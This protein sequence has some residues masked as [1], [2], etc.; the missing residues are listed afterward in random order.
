[1]DGVKTNT[2]SKQKM[3]EATVVKRVLA[4]EKELF[5]ILVRR[6][7]Q[8]LYRVIRSYL[9]D[10]AEIEDVMQDSFIKAYTKLYQFKLESSFS[11]WLIRIG[12][13]ESLARL[14]KKDKTHHLN[15]QLD[16]F[17][18]HRI[19][20]MSD[21]NQLNPQD[22]MIQHEA[23]HL[24]EK[25]IDD[26]DLKYRTVYT[27]REVEG[28]SLKETADALGLTVGNVKVRLHR[29]KMMLKE[30]LYDRSSDENVFEFGFSRCDSV[31]EKV[32]VRIFAQGYDLPPSE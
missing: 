31:T 28:L 2:F 1:M 21:C 10:E 32:M 4:G 7:N 11:T 5:E 13:N 24:L 22:R 15:E 18:R 23:M 3:D 29:A 17:K 6:N 20:E 9:K 16:G 25:V 14:K 30:K 27:L 12:I 19:L 8:R 26:L